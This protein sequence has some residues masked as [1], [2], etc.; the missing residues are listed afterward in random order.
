MQTRAEPATGGRGGS[1][2][3]VRETALASP[4]DHFAPKGGQGA[5]RREYVR[6]R[7]PHTV[8]Y[9]TTSLV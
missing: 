4:R 5:R 3:G 8:S 2:S 6:P 1:W 7:H 9:T